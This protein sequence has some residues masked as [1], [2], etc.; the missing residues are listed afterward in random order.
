LASDLG[1]FEGGALE[2]NGDRHDDDDD[3][4][5]QGSGGGIALKLKKFHI[6]IENYTF[7]DDYQSF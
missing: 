2:S 6:F 4:V 7:R 3:E 5:G 1:C